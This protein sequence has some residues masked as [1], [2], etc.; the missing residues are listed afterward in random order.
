MLRQQVQGPRQHRSCGLVT[1]H[2]HGQQ[3]VPQLGGGHLLP[4]SYEEAQHAGVAVVDEPLLEVCLRMGGTP[5]ASAHGNRE[6]TGSVP[7]TRKGACYIH[8]VKACL[9]R[10]A[11]VGALVIGQAVLLTRLKLPVLRVSPTSSSLTSNESLQIVATQ[12][13]AKAGSA[14]CSHTLKADPP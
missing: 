8:S 13:E 14:L 11:Q 12:C 7:A 1:S 9:E 2:Q 10:F 6:S 3:V 5:S 4:G